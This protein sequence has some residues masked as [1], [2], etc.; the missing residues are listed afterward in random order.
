[1]IMSQKSIMVNEETHKQA[2]ILSAKTG[3]PIGEI[4]ELL[5]MGTSEKDILKLSEKKK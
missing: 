2:K 3:I 4:V 5:L 1:M